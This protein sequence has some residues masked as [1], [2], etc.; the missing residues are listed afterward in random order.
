MPED[1][2]PIDL[3]EPGQEDEIDQSQHGDSDDKAGT[4]PIDEEEETIF[5]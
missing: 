3:I 5:Y 2:C 1:D 4:E